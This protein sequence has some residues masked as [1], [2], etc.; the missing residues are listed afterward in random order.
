MG[1]L[2]V[3][4]T[5]IICFHVALRIVPEGLYYLIKCM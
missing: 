3:L 4:N 2:A 1:Y 5:N